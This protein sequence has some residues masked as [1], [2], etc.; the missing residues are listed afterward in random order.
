MS[1]FSDN[2]YTFSLMIPIWYIVIYILSFTKIYYKKIVK[3]VYIIICGTIL[4]GAFLLYRFNF[5]EDYMRNW[6]MQPIVPLLL[7]P[8]LPLEKK[9]ITNID[10][11]DKF[12]FYRRIIIGLLIMFIPG[13][14]WYSNLISHLQ[15]NEYLISEMLVYFCGIIT[16]FLNKY[17]YNKLLKL[18]KEKAK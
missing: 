11:K 13:S 12:I 10:K 16:I 8:Y 5:S 15:S 14:K 17:T 7:M 9:V 2:N 6:I 4:M 1:I 3:M 18:S